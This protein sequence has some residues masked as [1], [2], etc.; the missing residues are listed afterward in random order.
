M[1]LSLI[2]QPQASILLLSHC[3][4]VLLPTAS[5]PQF[6]ISGR[7]TSPCPFL[8]ASPIA[9]QELSAV[10]S[11]ARGKEAVTVAGRNKAPAGKADQFHEYCCLLRAIRKY[12]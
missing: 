12:H 3:P 9:Q 6:D 8:L 5:L 11:G 2:S 7:Q 10:F 4:A 1:Q